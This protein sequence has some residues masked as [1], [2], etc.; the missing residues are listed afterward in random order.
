MVRKNTA[1]IKAF[2][3]AKKVDYEEKYRN[4]PHVAVVKIT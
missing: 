4:Y 2:Y 1:E 3:N